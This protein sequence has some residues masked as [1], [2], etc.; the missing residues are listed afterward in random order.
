MEMG[1]GLECSGL[2]KRSL[3]EMLALMKAFDMIDCG[4]GACAQ[5]PL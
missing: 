3:D 4:I 1:G 5:A 2:L